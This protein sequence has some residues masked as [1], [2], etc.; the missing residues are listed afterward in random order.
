MVRIRKKSVRFILMF[1]PILI[2]ACFSYGMSDYN[3]YLIS[4]DRI[5]NGNM[6]GYQMEFGYIFIEKAGSLL[7]LDFVAFRAIYLGVAMIL[8]MLSVYRYTNKEYVSVVLSYFIYPFLLD[9][10]Q[11]RHFMATAIIIYS[12]K[13]LQTR[14]KKNLIFYCI[15]VVIA[16]SQHLFALMFLFLLIT[17]L[18][19]DIIKFF[20]IVIMILI[21]ETILIFGIARNGFISD[22]YSKVVGV[23]FNVRAG[24]YLF[25]E[26]N[27]SIYKF[28]LLLIVLLL[29]W[30][31]ML[32]DGLFTELNESTDG[33]FEWMYRIS[34][35]AFCYIPFT[36]INNQ[37]LRLFRSLI[38]II[39]I[40]LFTYSKRYKPLTL[41]NLAYKIIPIV[42]AVLCFVMFLSP[43]S[44]NHW[45]N[46]T[47]P[48]FTNNYFIEMIFG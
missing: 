31:Y 26:S 28:Y 42:V 10:V 36:Y 46:V 19:I 33:K 20:K 9:V 23:L 11:I 15:G 44:L 29:F 14:S 1:I 13:F 37:F 21:L 2:I 39:Y 6:S 35:I 32:F 4:Y 34:L 16:A 41:K 40:T 12:L 7:K 22:L 3:Q 48:I 5:K 45:E 47:I 43:R 38:V 17:Y 24:G 30:T 18:D 27:V 25:V 8:F